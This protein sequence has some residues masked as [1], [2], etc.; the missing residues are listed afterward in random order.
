MRPFESIISVEDARRILRDAA[1]PLDRVERAAL[2]DA[3][4]RVLAATIQAPR[5]VP[6]FD[7]SAMDG[8]AVRARDTEGASR[9]HPAALQLLGRVYAGE[10][11]D[12]GGVSRVIVP[13]TRTTTKLSDRCRAEARDRVA[14]WT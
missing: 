4:G 2:D 1:L 8:Y 10:T 3:P 9:A 14:R 12:L 7:R 6:A 5:D 11:A 13:H